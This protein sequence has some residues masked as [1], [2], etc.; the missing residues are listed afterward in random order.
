M[1]SKDE[2]KKK[3]MSAE[4][5][6]EKEIEEALVEEEIVETAEENEDKKKADEYL[7]RLKRTMAEFDN[8]RKRTEKET[9]RIYENGVIETLGKIL[10]VL[11]NFERAIGTECESDDFKKGI[12]LVYKNFVDILDKMQVKEVECTEFDPEK[13]NAVMHIEDESYGENEVVEVLQKGYEY[14]ERIIRYAM[15]KVAN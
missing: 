14:K 9:A 6:M 12:D 13:H 5:E 8:Y 3:D 7:D 11:D 15:V 1:S 10:P 2:K 4:K